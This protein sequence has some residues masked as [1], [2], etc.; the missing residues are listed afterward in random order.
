[1]R[2]GVVV[3]VIIGLL[4]VAV[5]Q[6]SKPPE[7]SRVAIIVSQLLPIEEKIEG[8]DWI[9]AGR[10][11]T[12]VGRQLGELQPDLERPASLKLA[13]AKSLLTRL[14]RKLES[15]DAAGSYQAYFDLRQQ[16]FDLLDEVG[17]PSAPILLVARHDLEKARGAAD[18]E[19]WKDVVHEL[20]E[21]EISYRSALPV[22]V[23]KGI[24][25][26][27]TADVLIKL[28]QVRDAMQDGEW[29]TLPSRLQELDLLLEQQQNG[30]TGD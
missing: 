26:Q 14:E 2:Y 9:P 12:T 23:E 8:R 18:K 5:R 17:Y 25:Q 3:L 16:L 21:V 30:E 22:L 20:N 19:A 10:L 7:F 6:A 28:S 4:L 15:G 13:K 1:M 29:S 27:Q 11:A 24:S